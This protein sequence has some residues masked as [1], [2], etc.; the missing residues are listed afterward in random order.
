MSA[1]F[2]FY[3]QGMFD[4]FSNN[5]PRERHFKVNSSIANTTQVNLTKNIL[6]EA[7]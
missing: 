2:F 4:N 3:I 7:N 1:K 6:F 5:V